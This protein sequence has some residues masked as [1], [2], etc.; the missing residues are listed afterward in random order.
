MQQA[1]MLIRFEL[2]LHSSYKDQKDAGKGKLLSDFSGGD[3]RR[4]ELRQRFA[5]RQLPAGIVTKVE[6]VLKLMT[7][8][9][10][11]IRK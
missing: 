8:N 3:A 10:Q 4:T 2:H 11:T 7:S 9:G 5:L 1:Q 6:N